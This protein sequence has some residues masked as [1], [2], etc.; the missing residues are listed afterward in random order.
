[1]VR[2]EWVS[3]GGVNLQVRFEPQSGKLWIQD[4]EVALEGNNAVLVDDVDGLNGPQVV[5]TL[6]ID[7][8][9]VATA[10][11][12]PPVYPVRPGRPQTRMMAPLAQ[13]FIRRSPE[14]VAFLRC[15]VT[16]SGLKPYEQEVFKM[17]CAAVKQP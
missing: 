13:E 16:L 4:R 17:W 11:A 10:E 2:T 9:F 14:L 15:D 1:M 6:R 3:Q 5:S 12:L 7:P 8:A